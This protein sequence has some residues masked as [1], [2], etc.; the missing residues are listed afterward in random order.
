MKKALIILMF[1]AS[2][3]LAWTQDIAVDQITDQPIARIATFNVGATRSDFLAI[4]IQCR[5]GTVS[6]LDFRVSGFAASNQKTMAVRVDSNTPAVLSVSHADSNYIGLAM[7]QSKG[8]PILPLLK[9]L[10]S[11]KRRVLVKHGEQTFLFPVDGIFN[12]VETL[13]LACKL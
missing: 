11:A 1:S 13:R 9:Q 6:D 4:E 10:E 7:I 3:A 2:P 12:A 5:R 8:K